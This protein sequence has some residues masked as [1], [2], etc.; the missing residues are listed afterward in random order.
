VTERPLDRLVRRLLDEGTG[1]GVFPGASACVSVGAE[2]VALV[3]AGHATIDPAL[4]PLTGQTLFDVA[5]LTKVMATTPLFMKL[6]DEGRLAL[7][8]PL[9]DLLPDAGMLLVRVTPRQLLAHASGLAAWRPFYQ[10]YRGDPAAFRVELRRLLRES[11]PVHEPGSR[12]EYSD[13]GFMV[14]LDLAEQITGEPFDEAVRR[15]VLE[16]V[17]LRE[18][19]FIPLPVSTTGAAGRSFAATERCPWRGR[20]VRGEV[21]DENAWAMGGVAAHSGLFSTASDVAKLARWTADCVHGRRPD[22]V[23]PRVAR[24]FCARAGIIE[25]SDR[26]LGWDG[27]TRGESSSGSRFVDDSIG[28]TGFTGTSVW[29]DLE[30]EIV[31]VLLTNRIHPTR[32]NIRIREYRPRFHDAV[33]EAL[34]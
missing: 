31:V 25:G 13:L 29:I 19:F 16:P 27:V 32:D 21:H 23:S 17:G 26:C 10:A 28:H 18:T 12:E 2:A 3:H 20:V 24:R 11:V 22:E 5:S 6:V 15:H 7:D 4:E 34:T 30:H 14:L 1:A 9:G 8:A 33:M